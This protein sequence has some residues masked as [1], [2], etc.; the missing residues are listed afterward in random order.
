MTGE[1][2]PQAA[3]FLSNARQRLQVSHRAGPPSAVLLRYEHAQQVVL[4]RQWNRL[5]VKLM[6]QITE[7]L[8]RPNLA[9]KGLDVGEKPSFFFFGYL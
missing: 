8:D 5:V 4:L 3:A 2:R 9:A 7:L 1:Q 6:L